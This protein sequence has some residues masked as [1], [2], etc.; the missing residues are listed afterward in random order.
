MKASP[1]APDTAGRIHTVQRI[2]QEISEASAHNNMQ[3]P[4]QAYSPEGAV[5]GDAG[6]FKVFCVG[7]GGGDDDSC[8]QIRPL[9]GYPV[10]TRWQSLQLKNRLRRE[11]RRTSDI[12]SSRR[13]YKCIFTPLELIGCNMK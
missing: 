11:L 8:S 1:L 6:P 2:T 4:K 10:M 12:F 3:N 13:R 9:C 7:G 5:L